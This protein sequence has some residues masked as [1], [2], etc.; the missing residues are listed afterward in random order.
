MYNVSLDDIWWGRVPGV[1]DTYVYGPTV[2]DT[3]FSNLAGILSKGYCEGL[4][5]LTTCHNCSK[6]VG[7]TG[8]TAG[9]TV[10]RGVEDLIAEILSI[11]N[12]RNCSHKVS[13]GTTTGELQG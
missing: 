1:I 6:T 4:N 3:S 2:L 9:S 7:H 8:D 5:F 11:K 12:A 10:D 13:D